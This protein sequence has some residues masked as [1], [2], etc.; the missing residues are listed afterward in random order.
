[1]PTE[2]PALLYIEE[3]E[4]P[5]IAVLGKG[6][7]SIQDL[8]GDGFS[9][10]DGDCNDEDANI[11]PGAPEYCDG[12]DTDCDDALLEEERDND[13]DGWSICAGDCDDTD[14]QVSPSRSE[15]CDGKDNDCNG[16]IEDNI[17]L[18]EDGQSSCDG[19]CDDT[20]E[21]VFSGGIEVCDF[22]DN[23]C[24]G[25]I[26]E[27]DADGDGYSRCTIGGDC[28]DDDPL[29][30]P[31]VLDSTA[32]SGG[33]GSFATPYHALG[34]ALDN[35]NE[36]CPRV[37]IV[38]GTHE[39]EASWEGDFV[40]IVGGGASPDDTVIKTFPNSSRI[41][42]VFPGSNIA[43]GNITAFGGDSAA[44]GTFLYAEE[45]TEVR[46]ENMEIV[47]NH[48]TEKG[49]AISIKGGFLHTINTNFS[50]NQGLI[51]GAIY[52]ENGTYIDEN[53]SFIANEATAGGGLAVSQS[54][55]LLQGTRFKGNVVLSEGGGFL[56]EDAQSIELSQIQ[57]LNNQSI[58]QGGGG[59]IRNPGNTP[60]VLKRSLLQGNEAS[61]GG[62]IGIVGA[63]A[64]GIMAN[65][66]F[67]DNQSY[68]QGSDI[69]LNVQASNGG[70]WIASNIFSYG[71]GLSALLLSTSALGYVG[72][73][74]CWLSGDVCWEESSIQDVGENIEMDPLYSQFIDDGN[75]VADDFSLQSLSPA[76]DSGPLEGFGPTY[77]N[78]WADQDGSLNDRGYTGGN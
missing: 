33:N 44:E 24:D 76:I 40:E 60:Y 26:D 38:S 16:I 62:G 65:N 73:N 70:N 12:I 34:D 31:V 58:D 64:V 48:S 74:I 67:V 45:N 36:N 37:L 57:L 7:I 68:G 61:E 78:S 23:D 8:D 1:M 49:G 42:R 63:F 27:I 32:T 75:L 46:L 22:L 17:D 29:S 25:K 20:E 5:Y 54:E 56:I 59:L 51:G 19:D 9:P 52:I 4:I 50:Y 69:L 13:G 10:D 55:V 43:I 6:G 72:H 41:L 47:D 66:T 53:S 15:Q 28:D 18:D 77:H 2:N 3:E 30:F 39:L 35:L 14:N 71:N 11:Y 21:T